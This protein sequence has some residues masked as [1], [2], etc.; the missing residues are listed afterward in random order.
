MQ[1]PCSR[2][3]RDAGTAWQ[4]GALALP[5]THPPALR[6]PALGPLQMS[7]DVEDEESLHALYSIFKQ[8]ERGCRF[9]LG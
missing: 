9:F 1:L 2:S 5:G 8:S 3:P 4:A 7:E 6:L